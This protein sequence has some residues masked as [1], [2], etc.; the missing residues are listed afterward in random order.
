MQDQGVLVSAGAQDLGDVVLHR[1]PERHVPLL[2]LGQLPAADDQARYARPLPGHPAAVVPLAA[3]ALAACGD[4]DE[5]GPS[6]TAATGTSAAETGCTT[7]ETGP[8]QIVLVND[9]R[10]LRV[11]AA[12]RVLRP[13][14][15]AIAGLLAAGGAA[16]SI[17][18]HGAAGYLPGNGLGQ[19]FALGLIAA[20]TMT[21]AVQVLG[22]LRA[23]LSLPVGTPEDAVLAAAEAEENVQR[24][25]AGKPIRKRIHV[26]GRIVNFVV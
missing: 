4:D 1:L 5:A 12:A 6:T 25:I 13:D 11:D 19:A 17:S 20:E 14:G 9:E 21:I 15:S 22:K 2:P 23:T 24:A 8:L 10:G 18:G 3:L 26:P 16:A 7:G